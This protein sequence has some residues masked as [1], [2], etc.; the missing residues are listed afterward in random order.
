MNTTARE[1]GVDTGTVQR[2]K[3]GDD[4]PSPTRPREAPATQMNQN[5]FCEWRRLVATRPQRHTPPQRAAL[6]RGDVYQTENA[7]PIS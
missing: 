7:R 1:V 6:L 4:R 5:R 2:I 3:A